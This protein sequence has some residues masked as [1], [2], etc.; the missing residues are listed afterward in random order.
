MHRLCL[1]DLR[2]LFCHLLGKSV[3]M[4]MVVVVVV[5]RSDTKH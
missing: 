2:Y 4:R 3:L 5:V 1:P